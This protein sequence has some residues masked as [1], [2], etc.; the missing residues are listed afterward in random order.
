MILCNTAAYLSMTS[1]CSLMKSISLNKNIPHIQKTLVRFL[2]EKVAEDG[3]EA[4]ICWQEKT[5]ER[6]SHQPP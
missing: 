4:E 3:T 5:S 6:A 1:V 2:L